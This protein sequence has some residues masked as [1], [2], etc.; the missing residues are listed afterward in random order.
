MFLFGCTVSTDTDKASRWKKVS[1]SLVESCDSLK[2]ADVHS[3]SCLAYANALLHGWNH[4][5]TQGRLN[6]LHS[7]IALNGYGLGYSYDAFQDGTMNPA[8]TNYTVTITDH[9]GLVLI[10][11]YKNGVVP[12]SEINKLVVALEKVPNADNLTPGIC[13]AYSD[14]LN[15]SVGCVHNVNISVAVFYQEL[16]NTGL[17]NDTFNQRV[18]MILEREQFAYN[19]FS[20]NY[21][22]WDG[23]SQLT[24]QNHLA[25]QAWCL[26]QHD[27]PETKEIAQQIIENLVNNREQSISALIGHLR[28]MPYNDKNSDELLTELESIINNQS[29]LTTHGSYDLNNPRILAQFAMHSTVYWSLIVK[30]NTL[31]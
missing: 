30:Q 14:N 10:E 31:E 12:K 17:K 25:F 29:K 6:A 27:N 20:K 19:D 2:I 18:S 3:L 1:E 5:L 24:D 22:Y 8:T 21:P 9:V 23:S 26:Y 7:S 13:F 11:G 15:D 16:I 4:P 28:I